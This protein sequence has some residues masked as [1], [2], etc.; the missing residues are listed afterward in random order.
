MC[1]IK[2][3][4]HKAILEFKVYK[5]P[6][7]AFQNDHSKSVSVGLD[8]S[9]AVPSV[10]LISN[11]KLYIPD[12]FILHR[13]VYEN[14]ASDLKIHCSQKTNCSVLFSGLSNGDILL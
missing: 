7:P 5:L 14:K 10:F 4:S 9:M 2:H 13:H 8:F 12:K 3:N 11:E 6:S 1:V